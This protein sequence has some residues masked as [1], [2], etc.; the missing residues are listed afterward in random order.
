MEDFLTL[1]LVWV[2][3]PTR[4]KPVDACV[5]K[6][7]A[8][9]THRACGSLPKAKLSPLEGGDTSRLVLGCLALIDEFWRFESHQ[10]SFFQVV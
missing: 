3:E 8:R 4:F 9:Q 5:R 2:E 6:C 1:L 7:V 10:V